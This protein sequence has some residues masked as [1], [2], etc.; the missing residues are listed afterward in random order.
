M[1][2]KQSMILAVAAIVV[3]AC[4]VAGLNIKPAAPPVP[5]STVVYAIMAIPEGQTIPSDA[6]EERQVPVE[7]VET[8]SLS[9][10]NLV[11]G[12][13]AK[14]PIEKGQMIRQGDLAPQD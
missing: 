13:V 1:N 4:V 5:T 12:R 2:K 9:S 6:L 14:Y 11:A 7:K 10:A 3:T 8:R